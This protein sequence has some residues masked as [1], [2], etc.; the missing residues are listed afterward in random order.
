M[1]RFVSI[2][3]AIILAGPAWGHGGR[4]FE[5]LVIN[6]Q[7]FAQGKNIGPGDG[8]DSPRPYYNSIHDHWANDF[9]PDPNVMTA[10]AGRPGYDV[11]SPGPLG[12][13]DIFLTVLGGSKWG[14]DPNVLLPDPNTIPVLLP[15]DPDEEMTVIFHGFEVGNTTDGG[16][17]ELIHEVDPNG[18][19]HQDSLT[20][21]IGQNPVDMIYV[22]ELQLSTSAPG[23]EPSDTIYSIFSPEG[24]TPS[25]K[26]HYHSLFLEE[27][28]GTP[29]PEPSS[30]VLLSMAGLLI[31]TRE[32]RSR[33][34]SGFGNHGR[35]GC[36]RK[37]PAEQGF[38]E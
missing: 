20:Y 37:T 6:N 28:L 36:A 21:A 17:F 11:T 29:I 14:A 27:F 22:L 30:F 38:P 15:L 19:M 9:D 33:K 2:I 24:I 8:A 3:L 34:D 35:P 10:A 23:I 26:L 4:Q 7:L 5:I 18:Y 16:T 1:L 31:G 25:L 13:E 32:R 12:G